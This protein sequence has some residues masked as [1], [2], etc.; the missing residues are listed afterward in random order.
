MELRKKALTIFPWKL[1]FDTVTGDKM[2]FNLD[3]DPREHANLIEMEP[4]VTELLEPIPLKTLF[5]M[6]PSWYI[7]LASGG[8]PHKFKVALKLPTKP[9]R[10]KFVL[11]KLFDDE[12][13]IIKSEELMPRQ[14]RTSTEVILKSDEIETASTFTLIV[15]VSPRKVPCT[16]DLA[17]D[18]TGNRDRLYLGQKLMNPPGVPFTE[19]MKKRSI[20]SGEPP[21]RPEPPYI[22]VWHTGTQSPSGRPANLRET[23]RRKL[24]ALGYIQ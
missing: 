21:E 14:V 16:F 15:Q 7:E 5:A 24:K 8:K 13:R 23:T 2:L 9:V 12:G 20:T 6:P 10:G 11:W 17:I 3:E 22:L 18:G 4:A 1:I 19:K